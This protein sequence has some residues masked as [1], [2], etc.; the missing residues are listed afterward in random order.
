M[1]HTFPSICQLSVAGGNV[2]HFLRGH[3]RDKPAHSTNLL[4]SLIL[5]LSYH[6]AYLNLVCMQ[7]IAHHCVMKWSKTVLMSRSLTDSSGG[8]EFNVPVI[9]PVW[10]K[11]AKPHNFYASLSCLKNKLIWEKTLAWRH[12]QLN[13]LM[14]AVKESVEVTMKAELTS[15]N[16]VAQDNPEKATVI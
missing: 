15:Y 9:K 8:C 6:K 2:V 14:V 7:L 1:E 3:D 4:N 10:N 5:S 12:E 11:K 13:L 16:S